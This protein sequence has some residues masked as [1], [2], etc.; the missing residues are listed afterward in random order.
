[1][2]TICAGFL[3]SSF[4]RENC[5]ASCSPTWREKSNF[6]NGALRCSDEVIADKSAKMEMLWWKMGHI[7]ENWFVPHKTRTRWNEVV[8]AW[9]LCSP[10]TRLSTAWGDSGL[11]GVN[12][13]TACAMSSY[14]EG[15]VSFKP[16]ALTLS[17][18][19]SCLV[20]WTLIWNDLGFFFFFFPCVSLPGAAGS[21]LSLK[22][23]CA[24][25]LKAT[26]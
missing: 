25:D 11:S 3:L 24:V 12:V 13:S 8:C 4:V 20:R 1:M 10:L 14:S 2:K 26:R 6:V 7:K 19:T 9:G 17:S 18:I 5:T 21:E 23:A 16:Q 22:A 15:S